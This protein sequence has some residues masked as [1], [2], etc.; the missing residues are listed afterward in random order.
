MLHSKNPAFNDHAT[1]I[2]GHI[3]HRHSRCL[4]RFSVKSNGLRL[5]LALLLCLGRYRAAD[6][7][8]STHFIQGIKQSLAF[9][10]LACF[11]ADRYRDSK[12]L[13]QFGADL[14]SILLKLLHT[15]SQQ[16]D[17]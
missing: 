3:P 12:L 15:V 2:Q 13:P 10:G 1:H 16:F 5:L 6:H 8:A 17:G 11:K 7:L 14:R 9:Q 4:D